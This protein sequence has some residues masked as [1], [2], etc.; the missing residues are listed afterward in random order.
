MLPSQ[1]GQ[2]L[3]VAVHACSSASHAMLA[4]RTAARGA[5]HAEGQHQHSSRRSRFSGRSASRDDG[6]GYTAVGDDKWGPCLNSDEQSK[7]DV[8]M[9]LCDD[10]YFL[11]L[12]YVIDKAWAWCGLKGMYVCFWGMRL[13]PGRFAISLCLWLRVC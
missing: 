10:P 1:S 5:G 7:Q 4:G 8:Y 6:A 12:Q 11:C 3:V 9:V 2:A 13:A